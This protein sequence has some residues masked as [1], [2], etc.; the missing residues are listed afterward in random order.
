M[1]IRGLVC[2]MGYLTLTKFAYSNHSNETMIFKMTKLFIALSFALAPFIVSAADPSLK[3]AEKKESY[4]LG[5]QISSDFARQ[6]IK[7]DMDTFM[8]GFKDGFKNGKALMTKDEVQ[9]ALTQLQSKQQVKMQSKLK[10]DA[11]K[12]IEVGKK[13]A[14]K[15]KKEKG[16]KTT[17]SGLQ[18]K[19]IKSAKGANP[20]LTDT[21]K[22]HY[23]GM[24][25]SGEVFDSSIKRGQPVEFP[26][27][28]VIKGWTEGLQ[29]MQVGSTYELY[30]PSDLAYGNN[31]PPGSSIEPGSTL[32]FKVELLEILK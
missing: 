3:T 12:N 18:Y 19:V 8:K 30:I 22:V 13:Y 24:L 7:V 25:I 5:Y 28:N 4:A 17:A 16:V 9:E 23:E 26:L 31:P 27:Q 20:K 14:A 32:I 6:E 29:L 1:T 15:K 2:R 11:A 21:V 10:A